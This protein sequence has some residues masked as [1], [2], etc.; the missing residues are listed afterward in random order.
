MVRHSLIVYFSGFF[1]YKISY[2]TISYNFLSEYFKI[3]YFTI[4][5]IML[6][7]KQ[8]LFREVFHAA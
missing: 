5:L 8:S 3:I 4:N 7:L 2:Q 6:Y 1:L